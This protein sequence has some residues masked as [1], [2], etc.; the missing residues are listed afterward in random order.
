MHDH[1]THRDGDQQHGEG[2]RKPLAIALVITS[3]FLIV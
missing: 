3:V 2:T 1:A